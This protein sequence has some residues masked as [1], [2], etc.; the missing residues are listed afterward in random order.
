MKPS[1]ARCPMGD[2][3]TEEHPGFALYRRL[4]S[5][6]HILAPMVDASELPFRMLCRRYGVDLAY[7]P[8]VHSR[9]FMEKE[10]YRRKVFT[11]CAADRPLAVQFCGHDPE[12][13]LQAARLVQD[14]CDV[15][16]L[17]L[18]CPQ[19]RAQDQA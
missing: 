13:L 9:L 4:G 15:V 10:D 11:T 3:P 1:P 2:H 7:S 12:V 8:M 19:V 6:K 5:P 17:N 18:G 16:D 14:Q